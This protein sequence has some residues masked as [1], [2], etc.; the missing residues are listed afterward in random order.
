VRVVND[1]VKNARAAYRTLA[2]S[3]RACTT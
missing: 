3:R 1:R 2:T